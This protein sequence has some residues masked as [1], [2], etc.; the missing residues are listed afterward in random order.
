MKKEQLEQFL[1]EHITDDLW[2]AAVDESMG[3]WSNIDDLA[4][5]FKEHGHTIEGVEEWGGEG[6]GDT[7]G[8]VFKVD[9]TFYEI[10]GWYASH[11]GCEFANPYGYYEVEEAEKTV[12]YWKA[13]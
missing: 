9:D 4:A 8:F 11:Y 6:E 5:I 3:R 10:D 12:K 13:V 7:F 2:I 1:K